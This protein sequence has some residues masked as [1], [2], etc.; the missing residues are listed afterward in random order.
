MAANAQRHHG[1][2]IAVRFKVPFTLVPKPTV[3]I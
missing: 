3:M 2:V 1:N